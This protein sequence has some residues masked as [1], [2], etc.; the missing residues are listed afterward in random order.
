MNANKDFFDSVFFFF[1]IFRKNT[2]TEWTQSSWMNRKQELNK[3]SSCDIFF[4]FSSDFGFVSLFSSIS[5]Q[6]KIRSKFIGVI[7]R[8][9][10]RNENIRSYF[11]VRLCDSQLTTTKISP[12]SPLPLLVFICFGSTFIL[13]QWYFSFDVIFRF[14]V[15]RFD[16]TS[17][18][19]SFN[20]NIYSVIS[21]TIFCVS[22]DICYD[23]SRKLRHSKLFPF[24]LSLRN[25][26]KKKISKTKFTK[27][28]K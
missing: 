8:A 26:A 27:A 14:N 7:T 10:M 1:S 5:T 11:S 24:V 21:T 2:L 12:S 4:F 23:F 6:D 28:H 25:L 20:C 22:I 17:C 9:E 18:Y 16:A 13:L 3:M 15:N 19:S